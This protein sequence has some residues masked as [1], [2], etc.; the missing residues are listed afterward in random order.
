MRTEAPAD[1]LVDTPV[2]PVRGTRSNGVVHAGGVPYAR[3][4]RWGA[5][6]PITWAEPLDATQR[7][8]APPQVVGALD[9]VPGMTPSRQAEQCLTAEIWTPALDGRLPVIVWV[10]GGSYRI[11]GASLPTYDGSRLASESTVVVGCNYR[12]GALGWLAA[13]G[14]P[15][16]L[17]LRDL[18]AAVGWIRQ[19]A[20]AFGGDPD[21]IVLMG[22]SAGAGALAHLL[23]TGDVQAAGAILQSGAPAGTLDAS[24]AEWVAGQFFDAA[25]VGDVDALRE[26]PIDAILDA[27]EAAVVASL[28]KVGMMPFHP[29]LD[30]DLL[31]APAFRAALAPM[32]L[33]VT[34]TAN[35]MELF[36]DQ[37][38]VLPE[39]VALAL[40]TPKA[41]ALGIT[42]ESSVRAGLQA[43]DGDLVE[44]IAD[45]ELHVP[46]ELMA[47]AH[48]ARGHRVWRARF[49]WEAPN[50][51]ACHALD[52]PFDFGTLDV[53][54]WREFA[55]AHD[56]RADQLSA[57]MREA[58]RSF[59][60]AGEPSDT[61]IGPW[62][63]DQ[64][65]GL[66][67]DGTV[68]P[69]A[70]EHRLGV[71]LRDVAV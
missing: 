10:P 31:A 60:V 2:G 50:L 38:P 59:A 17:G 18:A 27:Q 56:P 67:S 30:A 34:T 46:N 24:L 25:G 53:S 68:G 39:H 8:A 54:G 42:D 66:G 14:V 1:I 70:V 21:R 9:L 12:L 19:V 33:V 29:F 57:R 63:Q 48:R 62:P 65:V 26:L 15:T 71:W 11:G 35:E 69:D 6:E 55:G 47:R 44:A 16:N 13:D 5:P 37:V 58:W 61:V 28:G 36:R 49:N 4:D 3:A 40:L 41:A 23:A 32:P 22:E 45:L 7:G 43:C 64:L 52:L 51:G 20:P